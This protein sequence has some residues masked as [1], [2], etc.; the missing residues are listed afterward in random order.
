VLEFQGSEIMMKSM[1][2][3]DCLIRADLHEE[4]LGMTQGE[5][6]TSQV[7]LSDAMDPCPHLAN[8]PVGCNERV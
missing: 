7:A 1:T 8:W 5:S 6:H 4:S 2:N 3:D